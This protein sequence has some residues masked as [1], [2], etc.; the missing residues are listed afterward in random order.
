M[1][2]NL[3]EKLD[4]V[5]ATRL[6]LQHTH[7]DVTQIRAEVRKMISDSVP[8][9][10]KQDYDYIFIHQTQD[11]STSAQDRAKLCFFFHFYNE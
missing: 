2:S 4:K 7:K 5:K 10:P 6:Q 8:K 9:A 1:F 11:F 3:S